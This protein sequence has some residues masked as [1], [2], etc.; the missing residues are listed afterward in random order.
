MFGTWKK[1]YFAKFS[2]VGTIVKTQL[3]EKTQPVLKFVLVEIV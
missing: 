2:L 3:V 1:I